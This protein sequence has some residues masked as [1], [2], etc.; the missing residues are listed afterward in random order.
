[1]F[2]D[3]VLVYED[4][5]ETL[6]LK[7]QGKIGKKEKALMTTKDKQEVWRTKFLK[8]LQKTGLE[9]EEVHFV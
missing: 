6:E 3:F 1:M 9:M 8:N 7:K 2:V 4:D 5:M